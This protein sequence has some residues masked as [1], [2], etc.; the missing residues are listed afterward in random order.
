MSSKDDGEEGDE[1]V[2][3][4]P[5]EEMEMLRFKIKEMEDKNNDLKEQVNEKNDKI[6]KLQQAQ[7]DHL[8]HDHPLPGPPTAC[9]QSSSGRPLIEEHSREKKRRGK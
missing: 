5:E 6:G 3:L 9:F 4:T 2:P 7:Q 8:T 1:Q